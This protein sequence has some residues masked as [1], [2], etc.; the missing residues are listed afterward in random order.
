MKKRWQV[1]E[2][3]SHGTVESLTQM[4]LNDMAQT[5]SFVLAEQ[6]F[7]LLASLEI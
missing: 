1:P 3:I 4:N 6:G 2:L 7:G 5:A